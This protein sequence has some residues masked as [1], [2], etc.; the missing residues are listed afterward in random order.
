MDYEECFATVGSTTIGMDDAIRIGTMLEIETLLEIPL[1][2]ISRTFITFVVSNGF[3]GIR[4]V[5]RTEK[6][7]FHPAAFSAICEPN[8]RQK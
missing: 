4:Q 8:P 5:R 3:L 7:G 1:A 6:N 2:S